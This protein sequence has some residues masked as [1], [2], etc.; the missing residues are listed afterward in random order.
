MASADEIPGGA[1]DVSQLK[2]GASSPALG[3]DELGE[4][5][6]ECSFASTARTKAGIGDGQTCV[7]VLFF[8]KASL[9]GHPSLALIAERTSILL[10]VMLRSLMIL[11]AV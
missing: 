6:S 9:A 7:T 11:F 8:A 5:R 1:V 2:D 4:L 10:L 3:M